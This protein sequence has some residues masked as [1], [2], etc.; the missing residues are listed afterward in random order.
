MQRPGGTV[1]SDS[2]NLIVT[3]DVQEV[4]TV[5]HR[6]MT[7]EKKKEMPCFEMQTDKQTK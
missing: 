5:L 6:K 3:T 1:A 4:G 7:L 2:Q